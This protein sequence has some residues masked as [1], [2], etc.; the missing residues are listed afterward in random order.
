MAN[1]TCPFPSNINPLS[2]NGFMFNISKLP[3]VNFFCQS[4]N[5]PGL[6]LPSIAQGTPFSDAEIPGD[7]LTYDTLD[8]QFLVDEQM[9]NYTSI[10]NWITALGFP[11][12]Y[13]QYINFISADQK[14]KTN[15]LMQNYSDGVLQ[16]LNN[17]NNPSKTIQFRDLFPVSLS[18]LTFLSTSDDVQYLVGNVSFKFTYYEFMV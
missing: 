11:Q 10:H 2:P 7:K 5:L 9:L 14:N 8:L 1:L 6:N 16:I 18:A 17:S 12:S 3:D 15:E 4:I 13:D